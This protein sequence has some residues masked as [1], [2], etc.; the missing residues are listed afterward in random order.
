M[1]RLR[2]LLG[3]EKAPVPKPDLA[4]VLSGGGARTAYQIGVLMAVAEMLPR[5]A[6]SPFTVVTGSSAGA[7]N[8][9]S[10]AAGAPNFRGAVVRLA[11]FWRNLETA[12]V[13]RSD[14]RGIY[15]K[16][17]HWL[18]ALGLGG[19]GPRNPRSL[20]DITPL[21]DFLRQ[22]L[23]L[24][25][26]QQNIDAGVLRGLAITASSYASGRS[27]SFY[28]ARD[29]VK[30]WERAQRLGEPTQL[31]LDHVMASVAIPLLFPAVQIGRE[32]FGDGSM[33]ETAPFS[34]AIHLGAQR[35]LAIG[36]RP[37]CGDNQPVE[38]HNQDRSV[39]PEYPS[40]GT[41]GGFMLETLFLDSFDA[42]AERISRI[43]QTL[44]NVRGRG[45][46]HPV[47]QDQRPL[48]QVEVEI[49]MPSC[50]LLEMAQRYSHRFP[51]PVRHLMRGLGA[52]GQGNALPSYLL[53][54]GEYCK[55]LLEMGHRDGRDNQETLK[56]LLFE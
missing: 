51:W 39:D 20:L 53:F 41:I 34:P 15:G 2:R 17:L 46:K 23:H 8:A 28:Q 13:Y 32:Y 27:V 45:R 35:V 12:R 56:R 1:I 21:E 26:L 9:V 16:G 3:P 47:G 6:P 10:M 7:I 22:N 48:H 33:R 19:L 40:L 54:D 14:F 5:D 37:D 11:N 25:R 30:A 42:D 55:A 52:F 29:E 4:L 18:T 24:E 31:K 44:E 43:N 36:T 49:M 38:A 50:D